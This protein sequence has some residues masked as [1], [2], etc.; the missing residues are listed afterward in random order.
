MLLNIDLDCCKAI[1]VKVVLHIDICRSMEE[2]L[3]SIP[4]VSQAT[5][6]KT[7]VNWEDCAPPYAVDEHV[8]W[9][10]SCSRNKGLPCD[11]D[12]NVHTIG[13]R[14]AI[15]RA[16]TKVMESLRSVGMLEQ[17]QMIPLQVLSDPSIQEI[18][19]SIGINMKEIKL[20]QQLLRCARKL[21]WRTKNSPDKNGD[22][23]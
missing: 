16:K 6:N 9:N 2:V 4:I 5:L 22:Q 12:P 14:M 15:L 20:E 17:Q 11:P 18:S 10:H 1:I 13:E 8:F 3:L 23:C 7:L 19:L 21:K